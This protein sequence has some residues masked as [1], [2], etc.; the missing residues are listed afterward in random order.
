[1][2]LVLPLAHHAIYGPNGW[3]AYGKKKTEYRQLQQELLQLQA[4]NEALE[5]RVQ[6][7]READPR[8]IEREA[9]EQLRYAKPGEI[10]LVIPEQGQRQEANPAAGSQKP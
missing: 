8:A 7:L 2:L 9:R 10:V 4:Q 6:S 5:R 1:M 3:I